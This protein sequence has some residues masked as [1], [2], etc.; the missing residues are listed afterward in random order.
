MRSEWADVSVCSADVWIVDETVLSK[1][2]GLSSVS[3]SA[4]Y[5]CTRYFLWPFI[6][7]LIKK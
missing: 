7:L 2:D 3:L 6:D 4:V 1:R 5:A